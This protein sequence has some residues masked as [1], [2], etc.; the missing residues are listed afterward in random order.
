MFFCSVFIFFY[1]TLLHPFISF[2]F[3]ILFYS[4][5]KQTP[6]HV[7]RKVV[8]ESRNVLQDE[9]KRKPIEL[10]TGQQYL[11]NSPLQVTRSFLAPTSMPHPT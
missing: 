4:I 5:A 11:T 9:E 8:K 1:S 7:T 2:S 10:M 6:G 3:R